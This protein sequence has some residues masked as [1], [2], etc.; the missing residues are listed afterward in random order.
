MNYSVVHVNKMVYEHREVVKLEFSYSD[1]LVKLVK[2]LPGAKWDKLYRMWY[3]EKRTGLLN[4][5]LNCFKGK[6]YLDYKALKNETMLTAQPV[7][8]CKTEVPQ[9]VKSVY[10]NNS[11]TSP[12]KQSA[13]KQSAKAKQYAL[14]I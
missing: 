6:A 4:E 13:K 8:E 2:S 1:E 7:L 10:Y 5:V 14:F 12:V 11:K 9:P 3:I